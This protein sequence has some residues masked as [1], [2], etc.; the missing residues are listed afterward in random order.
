MRITS[1]I[2]LC[3]M[4]SVAAGAQAAD[5][6]IEGLSKVELVQELS[7]GGRTQAAG[8]ERRQFLFCQKR[9]LGQH[10]R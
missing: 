1:I 10:R 2:C 4:L 7:I 5:M 6:S 3:L 9:W 8:M